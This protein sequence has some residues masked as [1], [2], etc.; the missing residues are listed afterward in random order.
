MLHVDI[1]QDH[2]IFIKIVKAVDDYFRCFSI[3]YFSLGSGAR[4]RNLMIIKIW[5]HVTCSL[6]EHRNMAT[7]LV[8]L[9]FTTG[10]WKQSLDGAQKYPIIV[11]LL[12]VLI[13][14]WGID[15]KVKFFPQCLF[16]HD[17]FDMNQELIKIIIIY[18]MIFHI[19]TLLSRAVTGSMDSSLMIWHF[20]PHMRAYRFVGHKVWL[21]FFS[22][23]L[24][25]FPYFNPLSPRNSLVILFIV[26]R[27]W[28]HTTIYLP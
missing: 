13:V 21:F 18:S 19:S 25:L 26:C 28:L 8:S 1:R 2:G 6:Q 17:S 10:A 5:L 23:F 20:K 4:S 27:A 16:R 22:S 15:K 11:E 3:L 14:S 7:W 12:W 9:L 24:C